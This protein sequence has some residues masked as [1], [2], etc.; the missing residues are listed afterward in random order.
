MHTYSLQPSIPSIWHKLHG[1]VKNARVNSQKY[2]IHQHVCK[3][4]LCAVIWNDYAITRLKLFKR[5]QQRKFIIRRLE[6]QQVKE[7]ALTAM[8]GQIRHQ[9]LLVYSYQYGSYIRNYDTGFRLLLSERKHAQGPN[10][11]IIVMHLFIPIFTHA[12]AISRA[13]IQK[14]NTLIQAPNKRNK[15]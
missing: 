1:H 4:N 2:C 9:P 10:S 6:G 15:Y 14:R 5:E 13:S 3:N 8:H 7:R 11:I 12:V